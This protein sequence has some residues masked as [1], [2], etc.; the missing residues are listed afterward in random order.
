MV[1]LRE[2]LALGYKVQSWLERL[3]KNIVVFSRT[4]AIVQISI[5]IDQLLVLCALKLQL[6][7]TYYNMTKLSY[8]A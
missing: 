2:R 5:W 6:N 7:W 4:Q 3:T 8:V 1:H